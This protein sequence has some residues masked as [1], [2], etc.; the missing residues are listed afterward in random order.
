MYTRVERHFRESTSIRLRLTELKQA[1]LFQPSGRCGLGGIDLVPSAGRTLRQQALQQL[2]NAQFA[3]SSHVAAAP[4]LE[5]RRRRLLLLLQQGID[6]FVQVERRD[7]EAVDGLGL[8]DAAD[9]V[10]RLTGLPRSP[11]SVHQYD[12]MSGSQRES[13][14]TGAKRAHED[15][16]EAVLEAVH[17]VL[18]LLGRGLTCEQLACPTRSRELPVDGLTRVDKRAEDDHRRLCGQDLPGQ[19]HG[20]VRLGQSAHKSDALDGP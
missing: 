1:R 18:S 2:V 15:G 17:H 16:G 14:S 20:R 11:R 9:A 5:D 12:R 7:P 13:N 8:P 10:L 3:R 19:L 4:V 6:L